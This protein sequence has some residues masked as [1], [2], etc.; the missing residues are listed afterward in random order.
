MI[1]ESL[2]GLRTELGQY[3]LFRNYLLTQ[4]NVQG[5]EQRN[6]YTELMQQPEQQIDRRALD[7]KEEKGNL[8]I[9]LADF[10][11]LRPV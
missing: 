4:A 11:L 2:N 3:D 10:V 9:F 7:Y 1:F 6:L 8:Q 5:V